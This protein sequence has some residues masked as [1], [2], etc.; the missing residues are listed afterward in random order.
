MAIIEGFRVQNFRVLHNVSLG[1]LSGDKMTDSLTPLT[2][3]IGKN[4]AGKSTLFDALGFVADC[5]AF[6]LETACNIKQRGGFDGIRSQ[7]A[8]GPIQIELCYR[9]EPDACPITWKIQIDQDRHGGPFVQSEVLLQ[10][11]RGQSRGRPYP[12]LQLE[13]GQGTVWAGDVAIG[14]VKSKGAPGLPVELTDPRQLGICVLG[15]LKEHPRIC[16]FRDF[17][18]GWYL[19]DFSP[20]AAR[21]L[22]RAGPQRHLNVHGDNMANVVQFM[23]PEHKA[24]FGS[25]LAR[26]ASKI[27]GLVRIDTRVTDDG[28]VLLRFHDSAFDDP[29]CARQVSD[30]TLR[31]FALLL[32]IESPEPPSLHFY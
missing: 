25:I 10:Q 20:D 22:P 19:S 15:T 8:S 29:F 26:M 21:N 24:R 23:E 27:P 4:G 11:R 28:R 2:V 30:G 14:D 7:G 16:R 1:R 9:E 5:L 12:F 31:L 3:V 32:L 17:I 13:N 18:K 6:D